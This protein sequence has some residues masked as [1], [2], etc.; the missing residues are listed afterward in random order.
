MFFFLNFFISSLPMTRLLCF[1]SS[2]SHLCCIFFLLFYFLNQ[3]RFFK[4]TFDYNRIGYFFVAIV[5][6]V[7]Y[8]LHCLVRQG[9][10][11]SLG[12]GFITGSSIRIVTQIGADKVISDHATAPTLAASPYRDTIA[13]WESVPSTYAMVPIAR[14]KLHNAYCAPG[15]HLTLTMLV[16]FFI[17]IL[18]RTSITW[19]SYIFYF[20]LPQTRWC[21]SSHQYHFKKETRHFIH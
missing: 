7:Q 6:C 1:Y 10:L 12:N 4:S 20:L 11:V 18:I 2:N 16:N 3:K 17:G 5:S 13:C 19:Y 14:A 21:D 15:I 9:G 8:L